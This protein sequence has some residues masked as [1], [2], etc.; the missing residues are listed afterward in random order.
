MINLQVIQ[1]SSNQKKMSVN[2][3]FAYNKLFNDDVD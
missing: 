2:M 3:M 1:Q